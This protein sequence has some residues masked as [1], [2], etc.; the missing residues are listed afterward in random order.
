[1]IR[2]LLLDDEPAV[3]DITST[4]LSKQE[5]FRVRTVDSVRGAQLLLSQYPFDVII[6]DCAMTDLDGISF[7]KDVKDS[8]NPIPFIFFTGRG[9]EDVAIEA[10]NAGADYYLKKGGEY[11]V[12][13]PKLAECITMVVEK[14]RSHNEL[15][16]NEHRYRELAEKQTDNVHYIQAL[17]DTIPAPVFYRDTN[18]IY[19]DCNKAF[20]LLV[21]CTKYSIVGR[22]MYEFYPQELADHYRYMDDLIIK[23]PYNQQY[24]YIITNSKGEYCDVL[25]SKCV[26]YSTNGE[27]TGIVGVILDISDRKNLERIIIE[28]EEKYRTLADFTYDWESWIGPAGEYLYISPSCERITGY[29][30]QEFIENP[31]LIIKIAHP[32]DQQMLERHYLNSPIQQNGIHHM[33]YRIITKDGQERWISH[34][35]QSVFRDDGTWLGRRESKRDITFRKKVTAAYERTNKKLLLLSNITRHDILNQLTVLSGLNDLLS[36]IDNNPDIHSIL[37]T[38]KKTVDTINRH[39]LF[40]REY[41][42]IGGT[43]PEW[44]HIPSVVKRASKGS[45]ILDIKISDDLSDMY[46]LADPFLEKIFFCFLDNS[47]RHG[48]R[49][50]LARFSCNKKEEGIVLLYEDNGIGIPNH[51]KDK[52][53]ERGYGANTGYGLFLTREIVSISGFSICETGEPGSGVRFEIA[54]P[55]GSW[56]HGSSEANGFP[57]SVTSYVMKKMKCSICGHVYDPEL[58][59]KDAPSGTDFQNLPE[60]WICPVCLA[61]K[62]LFREI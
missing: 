50:T 18:G 1:V 17:L 14:Y 39:I 29:T 13:L 32:E 37:G 8:K 55:V 48:K 44:Q 10:L 62:S 54:I 22:S 12:I 6:A 47:E 57:Y 51:E 26:L 25:F 7:L 11:S 24:E 43:Q 21:G 38:M 28:N 36:E 59:D 34:Y 31:D 35:C 3:L 49:V 5:G 19:R 20:E 45:Q 30:V 56:K 60:T 33:D 53:F 46:I 41:Q 15:M 52:I 4:Y 9:S 61:K 40:T 27:V 42:E 23:N 16:I 58:G 2:I